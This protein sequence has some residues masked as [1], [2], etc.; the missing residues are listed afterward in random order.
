MKGGTKNHTHPILPLNTLKQSLEVVRTRQIILT[1]QKCHH[2]FINTLQVLCTGTHTHTLKQ[3][4]R[5]YG[6]VPGRIEDAPLS[7]LAAPVCWC[8]ADAN[9]L[10]GYSERHSWCFGGGCGLLWSAAICFGTNRA[11]QFWKPGIS[12]CSCTLH[13]A[14]RWAPLILMYV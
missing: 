9:V 6:L 4:L 11:K 7:P 1:S 3:R 12:Q 13:T 10:H 2:F 8:Q 5:L 14:S